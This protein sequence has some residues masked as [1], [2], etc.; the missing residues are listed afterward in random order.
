MLYRILC[1]SKPVFH[2]AAFILCGN[3]A[4]ALLGKKIILRISVIH[5]IFLEV[6]GKYVIQIS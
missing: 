3:Q 1:N 5:K 6:I 2:V 4:A